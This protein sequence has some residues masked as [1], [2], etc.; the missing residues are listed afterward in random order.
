[1]NE[2]LTPLFPPNV[3]PVH[4]GVYPSRLP[5]EYN[6]EEG[7]SHWDG[8][9]WGNQ[10]ATPPEANKRGLCGEQEKMWR[11]LASDPK[12]SKP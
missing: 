9:T 3:K 5:E 1:M 10:Y 4:V 8:I 6:Y 7:Y 12:A 11:G 2:K